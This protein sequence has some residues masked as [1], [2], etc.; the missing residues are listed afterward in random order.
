MN[1]ALIPAWLGVEKNWFSDLE[2]I[3][4][5]MLGLNRDMLN[6]IWC[7]QQFTHTYTEEVLCNMLYQLHMHT[8]VIHNW[9]IA[10]YIQITNLMTLILQRLQDLFFNRTVGANCILPKVWKLLQHTSLCYVLFFSNT[11][12]RMNFHQ[13]VF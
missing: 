4:A 8:L 5:W 11:S 12:L 3:F 7:P 10:L 2:A 6:P 13:N 1:T 9:V